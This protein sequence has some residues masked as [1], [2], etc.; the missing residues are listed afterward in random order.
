LS[1]VCLLVTW[2]RIYHPTRRWAPWIVSIWTALLAVVLVIRLFHPVPGIAPV[3]DPS[4]LLM[5][6]AQGGVYAA[7]AWSALRYHGQLRLRM[8]L[9]LAD[10]VVA[11]RMLLWGLAATAITVQYSY[12]LA[13][14]LLTGLIDANGAQPA[15]TGSLGLFAAA[16]IALTFFPPQAYLRAMERRAAI[17]T[18]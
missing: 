5:L 4:Y 1:S 7:N 3:S 11:N 13:I 15:V 2:W 18:S 6:V 16:T 9:G 12:A 8:R 14:P 10:P 17:S